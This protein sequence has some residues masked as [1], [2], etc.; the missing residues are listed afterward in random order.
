MLVC[1]SGVRV[2]DEEEAPLYDGGGGGGLG[3]QAK[4]E[5]RA[6]KIRLR[7]C[8]NIAAR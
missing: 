6:G 1:G 7:F 3:V 8:L 5:N 4:M 2:V